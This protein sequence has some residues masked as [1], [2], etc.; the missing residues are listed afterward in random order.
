[1]LYISQFKGEKIKLLLPLEYDLTFTD[2]WMLYGLFLLQSETYKNDIRARKIHKDRRYNSFPNTLDQYSFLLKLQKHSYH[3]G[4]KKFWNGQKDQ[5]IV[6]LV[7]NSHSS[8]AA[9]KK[10]QTVWNRWKQ[11]FLC[12]SKAK[13]TE[14]LYVFVKLKL[15]IR[16]VP[17]I[18]LLNPC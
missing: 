3:S 14:L 12:V 4:K 5:S 9:R 15:F 2:E 10:K 8:C 16:T 13:Q 11:Y 6:C 7:L 18:T 17:C 1:M